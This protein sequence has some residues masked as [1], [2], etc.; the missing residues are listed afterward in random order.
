MKYGDLIQYEPIETV[1]KLKDADKIDEAK[2]LV[3]SYV[4]S[5]GMADSIINICIP[6]LQFDETLDNKGIFI[7]GNYGTGKSHLMSVIS[8]VAENKEMLDYV[9]HEELKKEMGKI[10]GKFKV[11]RFDIGAVN[12]PLR[13]IITKEI[14][15][16][17][18]RYGI[19][20][21]FPPIDEVTNNKDAFME[22]MSKFE[23]KFPDKGYLIVVDEL[24]DF[25]KARKE[26][27]LIR[28]LTF[29]REIGEI[30]KS[31]RLRF[32]TGVQETLFDNPAFNAVAQTVLKM[33]D[34]FEQLI[35]KREDISYVV[36][37]RLLKKN[38]RQ[39]AWIRSHLE[40]FSPLY[41]SI[42][43]RIEEFVELYPIH[44]MFIEVFEKMF[45]V[46][47]REVLKTISH[48]MRELLDKDV[49]EDEPGIIS[50]DSYWKFL[51]DNPSLRAEPDIKRV[52]DKSIVVE[53]LIEHSFTRPQY[54]HAALRIVHALSVHRF[55]TGDIHTSVGITVENIKDDLCLYIKMPEI[56]EDFLIT[57]IETIIKEIMKTLSWQYISYNPDNQQYYL[58]MVREGI[59]YDAKIQEKAELLSED[60]F[61]RHYFEL[62]IKVL[63]WNAPEKVPNMRIWEYSLTWNEKN[64]KRYGYLFMGY[65]DE[66][67]TAQ[68]P[69]D[70]YVY[71]LPPFVEANYNKKYILN[72]KEDEVF[73][74]F[75]NADE[76]II[77]K[78]KKYAAAMELSELSSSDQKKIYE[79]KAKGFQRDITKW[80][81]DN[82]SKCFNVSYKGETQSMI[83]WLKGKT[84][85]YDTIK[86]YIDE[87]ASS[88]LSLYFS[89]KYSEYP[90]FYTKITEAN[91]SEVFKSAMNYLA[92]KK[93]ETGKKVLQSFDLILGDDIVPG[94][95]KYANY[96]LNELYKL[97]P[98]KVL[99]RGDIIEN[100]NGE[101]ID[102]RFK[103][104]VQWV[105]LLLS[106]L[107]YSGD[108]ILRIKNKVY[109]A[110]TIDALANMSVGELIDF[111]SFE[112]PRD[113]PVKELKTLF[114]LLGLPSG[115]VT[116]SL[117]KPEEAIRQMVAKS[118][119]L[120]KK[121]VTVNR[122]V[123]SNK[124]IWGKPI[125]DE[126]EVRDYKN[127]L[128]SFSDFLDS[129]KAFNTPGKLRN[130][131]YTE[132]ELKEK[133][134]ILETVKK[135][136]KIID[137]K[138][139]VEE[140]V[141]YLAS[142]EQ[143][144]PEKIELKQNINEMKNEV[145]RF[146][147]EI[148]TKE[149][150]DIKRLT[151]ELEELKIEYIKLYMEYHKKHRLDYN[152]DERKK[153]IMASDPFNNLKKLKDVGIFPVNKF[154]EI[155]KVLASL[156]TCYNFRKENIKTEVLC[157]NCGY[158]IKSGEVPVF[159]KLDEIED[160]IENLYKE[161]T[162]ILLDN[163]E[164]PMIQE[165]MEILN[166]DQQ[167]VIRDF[168]NKKEL[169]DKVDNLFVSAVKDLI[170]GLEKVE[171]EINKFIS[172]ITYDGPV[173]VDEFKKRFLEN[174]DFL[175]KGKD[176]DKV[177]II[178]K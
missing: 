166:K 33:K 141:K 160:K 5:E 81:R 132:E 58:D 159:G 15:K 76:E 110:T 38:D 150:E 55:T 39:K 63:D 177:R 18:A 40:K 41:K 49:P 89:E 137:F 52:V 121:V 34:R 116:A 98:G 106:A 101:D 136:E 165:R 151:R 27:E 43:S 134:N 108:I 26:Q 32:M 84:A 48:L 9:S 80:I 118:E 22:M 13:N 114:T 105:V 87:A 70:F 140:L 161:W 142:A 37:Q 129:L 117:S 69:R 124:T 29:L 56:E 79:D 97:P 10:A 99:N 157:P 75:I 16:D 111:D 162:K 104:E 148:D 93:T 126:F 85:N 130:F 42:S 145:E 12:T 6:Q 60:I 7:V 115:L 176:K 57:T 2:R 50:Y 59:N 120:A 175:I 74:E 35:I 19:E 65:P 168:L 28:D 61:N 127:L 144:L 135:I 51:R 64:V 53:D 131:K 112:K 31:T 54:K 36:S 152:G 66:R 8:A 24:L 67:S 21:Y 109:D 92:G 30:T 20:F 107:V 73:F 45:I 82:V 146:I 14:E 46:E 149:S 17:L 123:V 138:N 4:V 139:E 102:K 170:A 113:I 1:I 122:F 44:P 11:L 86:S 128:N 94:N 156:K 119:E 153:K 147:K 62:L 68:P 83:Y 23:D 158:S 25:L 3:K 72:G 164:D 174:V 96:F 143:Q 100:V 155:E 167:K 77:E 78:I 90:T 103:L 172:A 173:T 88:C 71:F 47:K 171:I 133:F 95:S 154:D 163:I 91:L 169:P 125:F 178:I